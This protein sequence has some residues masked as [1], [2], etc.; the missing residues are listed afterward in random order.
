MALIGVRYIP[1]PLEC[2]QGTWWCPAPPGAP[3]DP[4][5]F[6]DLL[7]LR[8]IEAK[9][10]CVV[11]PPNYNVC[12]VS[13]VPASLVSVYDRANGWVRVRAVAAHSGELS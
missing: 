3:S 13:L 11:W 12:G 7:R 8:Q 2:C 6:R 10:V 4:N 5:W 9:A 1:Q